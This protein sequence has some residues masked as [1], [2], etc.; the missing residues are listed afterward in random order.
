MRLGALGYWR[1]GRPDVSHFC[2]EKGYLRQDIHAWLS[3]RVPSDRNLARLAGDLAVTPLWLLFGDH[4]PGGWIG[5]E[6]RQLMRPP[7]AA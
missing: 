7:E 1:E 3:G 6:A 4:P 2:R 5:A